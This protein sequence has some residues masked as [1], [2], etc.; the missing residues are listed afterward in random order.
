MSMRAMPEPQPKRQAQ[1]QQGTRKIEARP[2]PVGQQFGE[3]SASYGHV[4][5]EFAAEPA[6]G[7]GVGGVG[8]IGVRTGGGATRGEGR[9]MSAVMDELLGSDIGAPLSSAG[10]AC[11][12]VMEAMPQAAGQS[13]LATVFW[14]LFTKSP[15]YLETV[16]QLGAAIDARPVVVCHA[17]GT[18]FDLLLLDPQRG[19]DWA[20]LQLDGQRTPVR[21]ASPDVSEERLSGVLRRADLVDAVEPATLLAS[22]RE[23]AALSQFGVA[24]ATAPEEIPTCAVSPS[25]P[26]L[27]ADGMPVATLGAFLSDDEGSAA[28]TC[29]VT[30][31]DHALKGDWQRLTVGGA[32]LDVIARHP[33]SDSCLLRV[34][35]SLLDGRQRSGLRGPL[36]TVPTA[37]QFATFDGAAS[38]PK[39]VRVMD[40]DPSIVDPSADEL[41]R[42]YTEA[43]TRVADSGAALIDENDFI[44]GFARRVTGYNAPIQYSLWTYALMVYLAHHLLDRVALG[45]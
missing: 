24:V 23:L 27:P 2:G 36:R 12:R 11:A 44:V 35:R 20:A 13:F 3:A 33:E 16:Y 45:A 10:P 6:A 15:A 30:T 29:I 34:K 31:V 21:M 8:G 37:Y 19:D 5:V 43:D 1:E 14:W 9:T 4:N 17:E 32:P 26:L 7:G 25:V 38:G 28:D 22:A 18:R 39:R 40:W 42:I 41:V